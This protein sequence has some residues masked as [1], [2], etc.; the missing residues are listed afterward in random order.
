MGTLHFCIAFVSS[1]HCKLWVKVDTKMT[2]GPHFF[3][4]RLTQNT[5]LD[6]FLNGTIAL[7]CMFISNVKLKK[8]LTLISFLNKG[9][10]KIFLRLKGIVGALNERKKWSFVRHHQNKGKFFC[11][12]PSPFLKLKMVFRFWGW[13]LGFGDGIWILKTRFRFWIRD[14]MWVLKGFCIWGIL[15][16][17]VLLISSS[18]L[19]ISLF[20]FL[21]LFLSFSP[22][23]LSLFVYYSPS[24]PSSSS[25]SCLPLPLSLFPLP[26]PLPLLSLS[27]CPSSLT[28]PLLL[29]PLPLALPL[30]LL[31][32][33]LSSSLPLPLLFPLPFF[34]LLLFLPLQ[35]GKHHKMILLYRRSP[36]L[37]ICLF[38][39]ETSY[40]LSS[41]MQLF[42][43]TSHKDDFF[44]IYSY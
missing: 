5:R 27:L 37:C 1:L 20:S 10:R 13:D 39:R 12:F 40:E 6:F 33:L 25:P 7:F 8:R 23:S 4:A 31:P 28:L 34:P 15:H 38:E 18:F 42:F 32:L 17:P 44:L 11:H 41:K 21:L 16:S 26:L 9:A 29:F 2:C 14:G 36:L 30:P 22:S 3:D 35:V 43:Y 24:S 19:F